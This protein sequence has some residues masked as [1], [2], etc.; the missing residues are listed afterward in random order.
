MA[1]PIQITSS[2]FEDFTDLPGSVDFTARMTPHIL[3]AERV[4]LKRTLGLR[5]YNEV[6][7][8]IAD[9][10]TKFTELR[11]GQDYIDDGITIKYE[12]LK[13]IIVNYALA[14]FYRNQDINI[15]RRSIV[16]KTTE[17]SEPISASEKQGLIL[18]AKTT[19]KSYEDELRNYLKFR[20]DDFP[21]FFQ[22]D[23]DQQP[24][25]KT[26]IRITSVKGDARTIIDKN[27]RHDHKN[28]RHT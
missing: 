14:R 7:K 15:T 10:T 21:V 18:A 6:I 5:F 17:F 8:G 23:E 28:H 1:P 12:G 26:S 3:Q 2:D 4:D 24:Q 16:K 11:D 27:Q 19:A 22:C 13:P 9:G 20:R 25:T